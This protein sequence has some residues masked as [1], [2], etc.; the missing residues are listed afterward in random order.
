MFWSEMARNANENVF[1]TSKMATGGHFEKKVKI[2]V[3]IW[4]GEKCKRK[5]ISDIQNEKKM[6]IAFW[7]EMA[8]NAKENEFRT[9]KM[10]AGSHFEKKKWTLRLDLKWW[11]METKCPS[12]FEWYHFRC[13]VFYR[14]F[15]IHIS[16]K[17]SRAWDIFYT[18]VSCFP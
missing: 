13:T 10:T 16:L 11:E 14:K 1:W 4:N 7:S 8:R 12:C 9:S 5:L 6:K 15:V 2:C 18:T 17:Y 3:L